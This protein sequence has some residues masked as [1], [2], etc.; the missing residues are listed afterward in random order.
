MAHRRTSSPGSTSHRPEWRAHARCEGRRQ[1]AGLDA[2]SVN[3]LRP[4]GRDRHAAD[5]VRWD[6]SRQHGTAMPAPSPDA[7]S[8]RASGRTHFPGD[9]TAPYATPANALPSGPTGLDR[10]L[11]TP[12]PCSWRDDPPDDPH[13]QNHDHVRGQTRPA[14]R[15]TEKARC[16]IPRSHQSPA[17]AP[18]THCSS[19]EGRSSA[20]SRDHLRSARI[21]AV[22]PRRQS[23]ACPSTSSTLRSP[24]RTLVAFALRG[25]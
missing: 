5:G 3:H 20:G 13:S 11:R 15:A 17:A 8:P 4:P 22:W 7:S 21:G 14:G 16:R 1:A 9:R 23:S 6:I 10:Q 19:D 12:R 25:C 24:R 18:T 2:S